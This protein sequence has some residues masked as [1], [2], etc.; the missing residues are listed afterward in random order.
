MKSQWHMGPMCDISGLGIICFISKHHYCIV[1]AICRWEEQV[2]GLYNSRND[3]FERC[4]RVAFQTKIG[5]TYTQSWICHCFCLFFYGNSRYTDVHWIR[6][7]NA[8]LSLDQ[9]DLN[10]L[11]F[12]NLL[13]E[14]DQN[15]TANHC[16]VLSYC[17]V[18]ATFT[19]AI[20]TS[21]KSYTAMIISLGSVISD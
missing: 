5:C 16:P 3:F 9:C 8:L 1:N 20:V 14:N 19:R 21:R 12:L 2:N 15:L 11:D 17:Y 6:H 13:E 18:N 7:F 10:F 4:C